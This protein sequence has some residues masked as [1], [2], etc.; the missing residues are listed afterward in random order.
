[1]SEFR[2]PL[3]TDTVHVRI[4]SRQYKLFKMDLG[5]GVPRR[6]LGVGALIVLPYWVLLAAVFHLSPLAGGG[7]GGAVFIAP[8]AMLV[9]LALRP[10][11]GG[12]ARYV[13]WLDRFR[14]LLRR[15]SPMIASPIAGT[16]PGR[17]FIV[18]ARWTVVDITSSRRLRKTLRQIEGELAEPEPAHG[19]AA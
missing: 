12:R 10:D 5:E 17:P 2:F 19:H 1:M 18:S 6:K 15:F 7:K 14:F 9:F 13:L 11:A 4:E 8:A 3:P 16:R